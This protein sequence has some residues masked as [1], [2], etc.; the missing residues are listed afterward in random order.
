LV[1]QCTSDE[2]SLKGESN[3]TSFPR[4]KAGNFYIECPHEDVSPKEYLNYLI[5][6]N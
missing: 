4:A 2:I 1:T 3:E 6:E 5:H